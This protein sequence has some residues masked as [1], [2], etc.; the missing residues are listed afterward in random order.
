MLNPVPRH[1]ASSNRL[2]AAL[3]AEDYHR[4]QSSLQWVSLSLKT[5]LQKQGESVEHVYFPGRGICSVVTLMN[6]GEM[7]EVVAVGEEGMI[8]VSAVF[9]PGPAPAEVF[10]QIPC[11][12]QRMT[13]GAFAAEMDSHGALYGVMMRYAQVYLSSIVQTAACNG[14]HSVEERLARWLLI[15]HDCVGS[16]QFPLTQEFLAIMLGV[17]RPTVT[18]AAGALQKGGLITYRHGKIRIVQR[19][20]LE[21]VSCECYQAVRERYARLLPFAVDG[22][23]PG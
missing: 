5:V 10:V 3:P 22:T 13:V 8:G 16:D 14:L 17:H 7:V 23:L 18:L 1:V 6:N 15:T 21:A 12:A 4:L 9:G 20:A 2:L 11:D 19:A